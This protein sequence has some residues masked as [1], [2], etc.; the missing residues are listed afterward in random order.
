MENHFESSH[1]DARYGWHNTDFKSF[2]FI[3]RDWEDMFGI[4][5]EYVLRETDDSRW[6]SYKRFKQNCEDCWRFCP[7]YTGPRPQLLDLG[8]MTEEDDFDFRL[9]D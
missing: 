6:L 9:F 8:E 5:Q 3:P 2:E 1:L 4:Q 7:P